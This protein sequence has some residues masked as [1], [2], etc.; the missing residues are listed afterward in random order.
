LGAVA[1]RV[2]I[3]EGVTPV[4]LMTALA[5]AA[6]G[7]LAQVAVFQAFGRWPAVL[8]FATLVVTFALLAAARQVVGNYSA[9]RVRL[10]YHATLGRMTAQMAHD[11]K[12]PLGAIK[13]AAQIMETDFKKGNP[14]KLQWLEMIV[15]QSN[16]LANTIDSYQRL[17]KVE[18]RYLT[19]D[20]TELVQGAVKR[21]RAVHP[22]ATIEAKTNGAA[23]CDID[24]DLVQVVLENLVR[25]SVEASTGKV[26]IMVS[27][28]AEDKWVRLAVE[29]DGPGM[30]VR[31][32]ARALDEFFTTKATGS[33]LGLSYAR[34]VAE[35][36]GGQLVLESE[37]GKGTRVV[38]ELP[39][40]TS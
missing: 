14:L 3:L 18:P 10:E 9:Y 24:P 16:R 38:L 40:N 13:G 17:G 27:V 25:N 31:T 7:V 2:K 22:N 6:F 37:L 29:D 5:I 32:R 15:E 20:A 1:L 4:V 19:T 33:G 28:S 36:H 30:D 23:P 8:F 11:I 35:A 39:K 34:R 21:G 12:N 26:R